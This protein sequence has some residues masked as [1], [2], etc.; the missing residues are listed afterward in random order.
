[1]TDDLPA[2][3][4]V[5]IDAAE[6]RTR[7]LLYWAQQTA[8][9]LQD[10]KLLG[11]RIPGWHAWPDVERA[12]T[13]RLAELDAMR[14]VLDEHAPQWQPVEWTHAQN[15]NGEAQVCRRCQNAEHTEWNPAPGDADALPDGFVAPYVVTPCQTLRVLAVAF[16]RGDG[17]RTEWG[18]Q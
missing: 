4:T 6:T 9:T 10:P 8:L 12:C 11:K 2:W 3:L 13:E 16:T 18:P 17:Y 14:R 15:S 1:M 7:E 5:Q